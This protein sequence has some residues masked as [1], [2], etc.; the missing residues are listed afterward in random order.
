MRCCCCFTGSQDIQH[1][2]Y[3]RRDRSSQVDER[4]SVSLGHHDLMAEGDLPHQLKPWQSF[5]DEAEVG[6]V[7]DPVGDQ[8]HTTEVDVGGEPRDT[9]RGL[10]AGVGGVNDDEQG[11]R[12]V[13]SA[14]S[15]VLQAGLEVD[16]DRLL[17][18]DDDVL[19]QLTQ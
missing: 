4:S 12:R 14:T 15:K 19:Q 2:G 9:L 3:G 17:E 10:D 11:V 7:D 13:R 16:H 6:G 5:L 1:L 18:A 8:S